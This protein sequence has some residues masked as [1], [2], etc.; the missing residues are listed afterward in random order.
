MNYIELYESYSAFQGLFDQ[1]ESKEYREITEEE[2]ENL[3]GEGWIGEVEEYL[4]ISI[5]RYMVS[6]IE[7]DIPEEDEFGL[8]HFSEDVVEKYSSFDIELK[9]KQ[10]YPYLILDFINYETGTVYV[11]KI[12]KAPN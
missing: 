5:D 2:F 12:A 3:E 1:I 11:F 9:D 7:L 10:E 4:N 6:C 8:V